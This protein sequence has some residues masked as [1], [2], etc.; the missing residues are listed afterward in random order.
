MKKLCAFVLF[1]IISMACNS[2]KNIASKNIASYQ[3]DFVVLKN[4]AVNSTVPLPDTINHKFIVTAEEF[5]KTFH[6][7]KASPG[8]AI[9]PDFNSQAVVAIILPPTERVVSI[10]LHKAEIIDKDLNIYYT[11]TDTTSWTTYPHTIKAVGAVQKNN[12][13]KRVNFYNNN[14]KEKTLFIDY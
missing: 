3:V 12:N 2:T 1:I 6:M 13:L 11:I 5:H 7:T 9:V 4:Y 10:D 14:I 8:T